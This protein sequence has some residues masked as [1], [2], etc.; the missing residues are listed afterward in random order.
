MTVCVG[1]DAVGAGEHL[2]AV[3]LLGLPVE[4]AARGGGGGP[5][6]GGEKEEGDEG[7]KE[8]QVLGCERSHVLAWRWA[9]GDCF[10]VKERELRKGTL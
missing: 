2:P 7:Y 4:L 1:G 5:R 6:E 3:L 8:G 9:D 10:W